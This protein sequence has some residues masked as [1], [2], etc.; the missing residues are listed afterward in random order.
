MVTK[1]PTKTHTKRVTIATRSEISGPR[2]STPLNPL[3][4]TL[5]EEY[6]QVSHHDYVRKDLQYG[7]DQSSPTPSTRPAS[8]TDSAVMSAYPVEIESNL[9]RLKQQQLINAYLEL[10]EHV[11]Y[12]YIHVDKPVKLC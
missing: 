4:N 2:S 9:K 11:R 8:A 7:Y 3:V 6:L 12:Y 5:K 1:V 10:V